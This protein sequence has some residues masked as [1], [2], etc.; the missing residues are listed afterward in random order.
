MAPTNILSKKNPDDLSVRHA[1]ETLR[2]TELT[3]IP[4]G[5]RMSRFTN[6]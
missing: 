1:M 4:M 3:T 6:A 2:S 5:E